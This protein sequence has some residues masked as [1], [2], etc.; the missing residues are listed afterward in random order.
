MMH[1]KYLA[2]AHSRCLIHFSFHGDLWRS[3][4]TS[5]APDEGK[6]TE[7]KSAKMFKANEYSQVPGKVQLP[8]S[9]LAKGP[10]LERVFLELSLGER[11]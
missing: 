10:G 3:P 6:T 9:M 8:R 1:M 7:N 2:A 5:H 11:A 4:F